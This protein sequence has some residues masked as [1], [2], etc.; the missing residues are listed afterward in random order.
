MW[1]IK[2]KSEQIPAI[3]P[4]VRLNG[5]V[6]EVV[7]GWVTVRQKVL[8]RQHNTRRPTRNKP[9]LDLQHRFVVSIIGT[10]S[11]LFN[12]CKAANVLLEN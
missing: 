12:C 2:R 10:T 4:A 6:L 5:S 8:Q 11:F 3:R 1:Q 7:V 9:L